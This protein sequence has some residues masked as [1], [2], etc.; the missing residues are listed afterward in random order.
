MAIRKTKNTPAGPCSMLNLPINN[1]PRTHSHELDA[2][3][4]TIHIGAFLP[5]TQNPSLFVLYVLLMLYV[6]DM[7]NAKY[8][9]MHMYN[10]SI[11]LIMFQ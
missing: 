11:I 2:L 7:V 5:D 6:D 3:V 10:G 9:P 4:E 1:S 8:R